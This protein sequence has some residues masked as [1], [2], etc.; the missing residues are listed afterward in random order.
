MNHPRYNHNIGSSAHI[1]RLVVFFIVIILI[2]IVIPVFLDKN[3]YMPSYKAINIKVHTS[4][5]NLKSTDLIITNKDNNK[6]YYVLKGSTVELILNI[7]K[8]SQI[9]N[10]QTLSTNNVLLQQQAPVIDSQHSQY[11]IVY[12]A[13]KEGA[14]KITYFVSGLCSS[15]NCAIANA[16]KFQVYINVVN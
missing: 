16:L 11:K 2:I 7:S 13:V 10:L 4:I 9:T 14:V 8:D 3:L 1:T 5:P 12:H 15:P 6:T